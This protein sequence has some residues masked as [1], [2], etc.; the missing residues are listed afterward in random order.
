[1][2]MP[3]FGEAFFSELSFSITLFREK[4]SS[5]DGIDFR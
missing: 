3:L 2:E 1:M 4:I 5:N